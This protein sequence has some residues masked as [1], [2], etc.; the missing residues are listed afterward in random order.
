MWMLPL[1]IAGFA[2]S[3]VAMG[4]VHAWVYN[5]T[6]SVPLN[7]VLHAWVNVTN[8]IVFMVQPNPLIPIATAGMT[9]AFAAWVLRDSKRS[10]R[11]A[12]TEAV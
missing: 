1:T 5:A 10:K 7:I 9:W 3:I 8:A 12:A 4:Y 2:M 11:T 6:G